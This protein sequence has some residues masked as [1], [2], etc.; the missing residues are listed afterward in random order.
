[1][2]EMWLKSVPG[3]EDITGTLK[4]GVGW[5]TRVQVVVGVPW[6]FTT[7]PA[8]TDL[9]PELANYSGIFSWD[10]CIIKIEIDI[11]YED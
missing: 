2:G 11:V 4:E 8:N 6:V 3:T 10:V 1:M 9:M 5:G 7:Q